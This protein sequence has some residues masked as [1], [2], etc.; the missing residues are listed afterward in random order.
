MKII[1]D[2]NILVS[3]ALKDKN[4]ERVVLWV[5]SE[6]EWIISEEILEEYQEVLQ[7]KRLKI[8]Q[9]VREQFLNVVQTLATTVEVNITIDFPRD[10]KDA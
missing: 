10:R 1:I 7:R 3:A 4:P 2:T 5:A 8:D 6:C 9:T